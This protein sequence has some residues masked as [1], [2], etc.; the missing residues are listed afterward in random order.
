MLKY[1][2]VVCL[3]IYSNVAVR[4]YLMLLNEKLR[5]RQVQRFSI[6]EQVTKLTTVPKGIVGK[7]LNNASGLVKLDL[8]TIDYHFNHAVMQ[9]LIACLAHHLFLSWQLMFAFDRYP[10]RL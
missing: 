3:F 1:C 10:G 8:V 6:V 5:C 7:V 9:I 4:V 2:I